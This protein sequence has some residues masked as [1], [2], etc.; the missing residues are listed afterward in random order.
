MTIRNILNINEKVK[1]G[2][3]SVLLVISKTQI[4]QNKRP[5]F[6]GILLILPRGRNTKM[7][8][9]SCWMMSGNKYL[10]VVNKIAAIAT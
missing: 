3:W 1:T 2:N 5:N 6:K 8:G 7:R 4:F 10:R 9:Q